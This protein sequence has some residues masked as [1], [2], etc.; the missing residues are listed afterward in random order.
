LPSVAGFRLMRPPATL[1]RVATQDGPTGC[2]RI[3]GQFLFPPQMRQAVCPPQVY[4]QQHNH[5]NI[6][7]QTRNLM[8]RAR[9]RHVMA[10]VGLLQSDC[11]RSAAQPVAANA[12]RKDFD[13]LR[14]HFV[15]V[16]L[17]TETVLGEADVALRHA[18]SNAVVLFPGTASDVG[19]HSLCSRVY[20]SRQ[21]DKRSRR[22]LMSMIA[23]FSPREQYGTCH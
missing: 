1:S 7:C 6:I 20:T 21:Q 3:S 11:E 2:A 15:T 9:R 8:S 18:V 17:V 14:P 4:G 23:N 5:Y 10:W 16:E 22:S 13:L 19:E 12:R